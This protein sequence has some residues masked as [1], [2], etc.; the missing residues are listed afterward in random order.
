MS[1]DGLYRAEM[2]IVMLG[3]AGVP[4]ALRRPELDS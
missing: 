1:G 3:T 4:L 2:M